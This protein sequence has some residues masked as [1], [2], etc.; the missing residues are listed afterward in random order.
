MYDKNYPKHKWQ[1]CLILETITS[2]D[3]EIR[4]C[5]IKIGKVESERTIDQLYPLEINAE[6]VAETVRVRLQKEREEKRER[7]KQGFTDPEVDVELPVRPR[8]ELAIKAREKTRE[9]YRQDLV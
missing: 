4:R 2:A 5:K 3:G 1:L 6:E 9:L 7:L 8:R